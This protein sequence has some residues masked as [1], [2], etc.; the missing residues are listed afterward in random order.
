MVYVSCSK[1]YILYHS[2]YQPKVHKLAPV[3]YLT[4]TRMLAWKL[5]IYPVSTEY[6]ADV[7][8]S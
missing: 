3:Q 1:Y 7:S 5:F 6:N 8:E 2:G 4:S